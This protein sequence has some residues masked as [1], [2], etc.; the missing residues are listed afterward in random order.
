MAVRD[1]W[2][3]MDVGLTADMAAVSIGVGADLSAAA[4]NAGLIC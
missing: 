2:A 4:G 1:L 3:G